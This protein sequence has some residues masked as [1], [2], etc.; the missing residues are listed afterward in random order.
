M[1]SVKYHLTFAHQY[2]TEMFLLVMLGI[3]LN[4]LNTTEHTTHLISMT[5]VLIIQLAVSHIL[6]GRFKLTSIYIM[7][8]VF[9]IIM[10]LLGH[11]WL[12]ALLIPALSAFRLEQLHDNLENSMA[13]KAIVSA[14]VFLVF[15]NILS[16][17][18]AAEDTGLFHYIFIAMTLFYFT[19]KI[20]TLLS[21][22]RYR[23]KASIKIFTLLTGIFIFT[24]GIIYLLYTPVMSGIHFIIRRLLY[25]FA[26][27]ISPVFNIFEAIELPYPDME[28]EEI[29]I[30]EG[31]GDFDIERSTDALLSV[32]MGVILGIIFILMITVIII[33]YFKKRNAPQK[34]KTSDVKNQYKESRPAQ[35]YMDKRKAP[36]TRVRKTYFNFEKWLSKRGYGRYKD[37]TIHEWLNRLSLGDII[38]EEE[39]QTY[40]EYRYKDRALNDEEFK[41]FE[42]N[43]KH[44]KKRL[45]QNKN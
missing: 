5:A 28:D 33:L 1:T 45:K 26:V 9:I 30:E 21:D 35:T 12:T 27:L 8:P 42:D 29:V 14:L 23:P 18:A 31:D 38:P 7:V 13:H 19:G 4:I 34:Q 36:D 24:A 44:M 17:G 39:I 6:A 32:N 25:G 3:L 43:I 40:I 11:Y 37:E 15:L 10:I 20:I 2:L 41:T 16:P 22:N